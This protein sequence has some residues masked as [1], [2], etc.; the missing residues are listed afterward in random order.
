MDVRQNS[1]VHE[2]VVGE[3]LAAAGAERAYAALDEPA[4]VALLLRELASPRPLVSPHG[5]YSPLARTELGVVA[6]VKSVHDRFGARAVPHYVIS[7]CVSVSDVLEVAVLLKEAGLASGAPAGAG[8]AAPPFL[9]R[10]IVPLFEDIASLHEGAA[11][12]AAL[13]A[14]P[15]FRS[16]I[17]SRGDLQEVMLGYSDSCKDGGYVASNWALYAAQ[18]ALVAA[19][20]AAGVALRL[21]HGRGGTIGRGGGPSYDAI[22]AQPAG[23]IGAGLRLT[24]QGEIISQ[25]YAEP[26]LGR[27]SLE[28]L[29][30]A[31]LEA[32]LLDHEALGAR[33]APFAAVMDELARR[34]MAAY[35]ALVYENDN[36]LP[37]FKAATPIT[38]IAQLNI[39]SRPAART[40]S[41]RIEDLRAIPWVFSW[42][43]S[44][45]MLPV[46]GVARRARGCARRAAQPHSPPPPPSSAPRRA[47]TASAPPSRASSPTRP[48]GA[49]RASR[50]CAT[51]RRRGLSSRRCCPTRRCCSPR[52]TSASRRATRRSCPTRACAPPSLAPSSA[53]TR[54]PSRRSSRC[55]AP[56]RCSPTSRRSQS[57]SRAAS[58]TLT[59][60]TTSKS[61]SS[62]AAARAKTTSARCA[63]S[64]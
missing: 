52:R 54:A 50:R 5:A 23:A 6:A 3:L 17:A 45:V 63:P 53:S 61:S 64:T 56:R 21:F 58:P 42:A 31:A 35:R 1:K 44:R 46:S 14:I 18:R 29:V 59:R 13:F 57:P 33:A 62:A 7:N 36:F 32:R 49:R 26:E 12:M 25:K 43:Q 27:R 30:A 28:G 37:Y 39:G 38:E 15:L 10:Q 55:A 34:S 4:R 8:G 47:G 19:F 2:A 40:A 60:S 48:A 20:A 11:T 22:L 51:W 9:A 24:E 41:A 16:W